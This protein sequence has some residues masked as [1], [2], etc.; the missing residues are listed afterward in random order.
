MFSLGFNEERDLQ[1]ADKTAG[2]ESVMHICDRDWHGI[3]SAT[4]CLPGHKATISHKQQLH[5]EEIRHLE[6]LIFHHDIKAI[7]FQGYSDT[8]NSLCEILHNIFGHDLR[9]YAVTHVT[10]VQFENK[11]EMRMLKLMQ[12]RKREGILR[13]LASVKPDFHF[14]CPE[15]TG[16]LITN[17]VPNLP[18]RPYSIRNQSIAF[19]PIENTWR[20]NLYTNVLA[21]EAS[22]KITQVLAV[23]EPSNLGDSRALRKTRV[24]GYQDKVNLFGFMASVGLVLNVTLA[25][26]Q[27]MT[28]LEALAMGTPCLTG[29][30][31]LGAISKHPL[32]KMTE[33]G[34]LDNPRF[35]MEAADRIIDAW[36]VDADNMIDM[37]ADIVKLRRIIGL[38]S[39]RTLLEL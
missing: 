12:E 24:V 34:I 31:G 20:K 37:I 14:V 4:G 38:D 27:P 16:P 5:G 6:G 30:L 21:C 36:E 10:S 17:I 8:A 22:K 35:I 13:N 19:V 11:F 3:R 2:F 1:F 33:V 29:P 18:Y 15:F 39:Y 25:E 32:S 28:Q 7:C 9:Q 26:C 23:N